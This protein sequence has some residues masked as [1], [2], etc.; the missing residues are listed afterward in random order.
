MT[1]VK[2][3]TAAPGQGRT[4]SS[5]PSLRS[6]FLGLKSIPA[7]FKVVTR[8]SLR[9]FVDLEECYT[10][11]RKV[12]RNHDAAD[13]VACVRSA[14]RREIEL[15]TVRPWLPVPEVEIARF[16]CRRLAEGQELDDANESVRR[17]LFNINKSRESAIVVG[18][19]TDWMAWAPFAETLVL[20]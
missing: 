11:I 14:A 10:Q 15:A 1:N 2:S 18:E 4:G 5:R 19:S 20:K 16:M 9:A 17:W 6:L 7:L 13:A 3:D 8:D 12:A